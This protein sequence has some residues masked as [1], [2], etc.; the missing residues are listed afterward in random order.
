MCFRDSKGWITKTR[1][2]TYAII[3]KQFIYL[4]LQAL[5]IN[6][7][8]FMLLNGIHGF[9]LLGLNAYTTNYGSY[10][11]SFSR[12]NCQETLTYIPA[13][14]VLN[15][16]GDVLVRPFVHSSVTFLGSAHSLTN[17]SGD[18]SQSCLIHSL[19]RSLVSAW[20]WTPR[21]TSQLWVAPTLTNPPAGDE[22]R[23]INC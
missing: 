7:R 13:I 22:H 9:V 16:C 17:R 10:S 5:S 8:I 21:L 1:D 2:V 18:W 4:P 3:L 15:T 23:L 20:I 19:W 12:G 14:L 6:W 11:K